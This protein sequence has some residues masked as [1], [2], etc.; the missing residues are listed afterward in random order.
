MKLFGVENFIDFKRMR[1]MNHLL[2]VVLLLLLAV[3]VL[4]VYSSC[5]IRD[6]VA[7]RMQYVRH[8][9]VAV[10][11]LAAY[12]LL[13]CVDYQAL[14]R[15]APVYYIA[16]LPLLVL[17]LI[18]SIGTSIMGARRWVFGIQ[19]SELAKLALI[20]MLAHFFGTVKKMNPVVQYLIALAIAALPV[21]LILMQPDLSTSFVFL[22]V[23]MTLLYAKGC[24]P[25]LFW[26]HV[27][28]TVVAAVYILGLLT[29]SEQPWVAPDHAQLMR[30]V[31]LLSDYQQKRI[32]T[33]IF[34]D[35]DRFNTGWTR[36]Q[37]EIAV[38]SGGLY[39]K[40]L[41]KGDR[42]VLG[43]LP[44]TVSSND[45]IFSVLAEET[46]FA[47]GTVVILL[48]IGLCLLILW[49]AYACPDAV[50][51]LFCTGIASVIF[52]HTFVNIAMTIGLMPVTG[53]PLPFIS[54]GRTFLFVLL[55]ALGF[56]QGVAACR[57]ERR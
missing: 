43:Y 29:L 47:G 5:S 39:G 55:V 34:P 35:R 17:V 10:V 24:A 45:F 18:P 32:L 41:K 33:F 15:L 31:T 51:R 22:I 12:F 11:G 28:L 50:G 49:T 52:W 19:P 4:S 7:L 56:V 53:L 42:N 37:S 25:K 3:G 20:I 1:R 26:T 44:A 46:G 57:D 36:W 38:G 21:G 8:A 27:V 2:T 16:T 23:T 9:E 48:E 14:F 30:R 54:Y 6:T 13:A 40:G